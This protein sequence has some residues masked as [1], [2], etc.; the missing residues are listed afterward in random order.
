MRLAGFSKCSLY[1]RPKYE[2]SLGTFSRFPWVWLSRFNLVLSQ[3]YSSPIQC[4]SF[5]RFFP[6]YSWWGR[7]VRFSKSLILL[8]TKIC[9]FVGEA[10]VFPVVVGWAGLN[11]FSQFY[12]REFFPRNVWWAVLLARLSK[13]SPYL[14]PKHVSFRFPFPTLRAVVSTP[15]ATHRI[16]FPTSKIFTQ[17]LDLVSRIQTH[18]W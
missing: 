4:N 12:F 15:D 14:R 13:P 17:C 10:V 11:C 1:F 16:L 9:N 6:G 5:Q 2:I 3:F 8:Q 7:A 18:F